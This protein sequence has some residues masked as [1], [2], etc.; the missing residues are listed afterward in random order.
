MQTGFCILPELW[1]E[2]ERQLQ[3]PRVSVLYCRGRLPLEERQVF[4]W[5]RLVIFLLNLANLECQLDIK[6]KM[7]SACFAPLK[8]WL[9]HLILCLCCFWNFTIS[10][11]ILSGLYNKASGGIAN[12]HITHQHTCTEKEIGIVLKCSAARWPFGLCQKSVKE[13]ARGNGSDHP[14]S[15][16]GFGDVVTTA[17]EKTGWLH[18]YR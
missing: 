14:Q 18:N 15:R 3:K 12:V 4:H 7:I 8:K 10:E 13:E 6:L 1:R 2:N 16:W 17:R 9:W 11:T 5:F